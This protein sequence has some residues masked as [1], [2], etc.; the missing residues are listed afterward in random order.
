MK[1]QP[2]QTA[3]PRPATPY[4]EFE[5]LPG[6]AG[7]VAELGL[8]A[9]RVFTDP[10]IIVW[11]A[12]P[13]RENATLDH[14]RADRTRVRLHVKRYPDAATASREVRGWWM[15]RQAG[16]PTAGM[17]AYGAASLNGSKRGFVILEDLA[18]FTPADK[19]LEQ[20]FDFDRL[21]DATAGL[22]ALLHNRCLHHRDLYLCHFMI[23]PTA[24]S[25]E[26]RLIDMARVSR[27]WNPLTRRRWIVKDLAQFWYSTQSLSVSDEQRERWLRRYCDKR[28]LKPSGLR[29]AIERKAH[30][31]ARHDRILRQEQPHR[32]IS[33]GDAVKDPAR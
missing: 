22:A 18:G 32:N 25:A 1:A 3:S 16:V 28:G 12:L 5:V 11:R 14:Q 24:G 26:A 8:D 15:L 23:K 20:G 33:I 10:R 21:L 9:G 31:I 19:M 30:A 29:G 17:V 2:S 4:G 6:Y 27:L 7:L 13:D